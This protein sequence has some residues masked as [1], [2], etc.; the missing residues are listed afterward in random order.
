MGLDNSRNGGK[1]DDATLMCFQNAVSEE[2]RKDGVGAIN[3]NDE[4]TLEGSIAWKN[5]ME[6]NKLDLELFLYS[7][8]LYRYQIGLG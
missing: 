8:M 1:L 7:E 5:I 4:E 6:K 2:S 3:L